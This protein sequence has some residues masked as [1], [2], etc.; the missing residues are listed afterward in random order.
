MASVVL[1]A[2][3]AITGRGQGQQGE[4]AVQPGF[5]VAHLVAKIDGQTEHVADADHYGQLPVPGQL[6]RAQEDHAVNETRPQ[7]RHHRPGDHAVVRVG[8]QARHGGFGG[9]A[10]VFAEHGIEHG[11]GDIEQRR[12]QQQPGRLTGLQVQEGA[13][14]GAQRGDDGQQP[15]ETLAV[16]VMLGSGGRRQQGCAHGGSPREGRRDALREREG[17]SA[18]RWLG[19]TA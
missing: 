2:E 5:L 15:G 3:V 13:G 6:M 4:L 10:A 12:K 18:G 11:H 19:I 7:Q 16:A 17:V 1:H 8:L 9:I 14:R